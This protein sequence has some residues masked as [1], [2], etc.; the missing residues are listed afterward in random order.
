[1]DVPHFG[2]HQLR[3]L[4][5]SARRFAETLPPAERK[6]LLAKARRLLREAAQMDGDDDC[7]D[8]D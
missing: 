4:A 5:A 6:V 7:A 2:P 1:M 3:R 8:E